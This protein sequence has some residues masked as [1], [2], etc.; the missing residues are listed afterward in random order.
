MADGIVDGFEHAGNAVLFME[1]N[2]SESLFLFLFVEVPVG[3]PNV[4][5][6]LNPEVELLIL[7][8]KNSSGAVLNSGNFV[9]SVL[10]PIRFRI[11]LE[12]INLFL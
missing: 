11:G 6:S 10:L 5:S 1:G 2:D 12:E 4:D 8:N 9:D 7:A 3:H